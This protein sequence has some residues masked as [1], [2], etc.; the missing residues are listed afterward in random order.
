MEMPNLGL[1]GPT[2]AAIP[3]YSAYYEQ[4]AQHRTIVSYDARG[5]G[6]SAARQFR[7]SEVTHLSELRAVVETVGDEPLTLVASLHAGITAMHYAAQHPD[8]VERLIL[9]Q[10]FLTDATFHAATSITAMRAVLERDFHTYVASVLGNY[11]LPTPDA[12]DTIADVWERHAD[13]RN[14]LTWTEST[15]GTSAEDVLDR[16][17]EVVVLHREE[18]RIPPIAFSEELAARIPG[19]QLQVLTSDAP[20]LPWGDT[21]EAVAAVVGTPVHHAPAEAIRS[22]LIHGCG[23]LHGPDRPL[24]RCRGTRP[25]ARARTPHERRPSSTRR[26]GDQDDGRRLHGLV[27]LGLGGVGCLHRDA[28]SPHRS[29]RPNETPIRIRVGINAGEPIEE[30]DDLYGT[31]VIQAARVMGLAD[32]G[33]ILVTDTVRNLVAGKAYP[34]SD[35]RHARLERL[36]GAGT[37]G[38]DGVAGLIGAPTS[39]AEREDAAQGRG[40]AM[41]TEWYSPQS[42]LAETD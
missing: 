30:N 40:R 36:R 25:A 5:F 34:F 39:K 19:T 6:R 27:H 10:C 12:A 29:L 33:Q 22:I 9:F 15:R 28:A 24:R 26:H 8:R 41:L 21:E 32:G 23:S 1:A 17:P 11:R 18:S 35:P 37:A 2:L 14:Y 42:R 7:H 16:L 13:G 20:F 31:A 3:S 4:L 38:R